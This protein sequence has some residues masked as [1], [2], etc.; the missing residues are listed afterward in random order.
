MRR[1]HI[2]IG[3]EI[4]ISFNYDKSFLGS[5]IINIANN[6]FIGILFSSDKG[7]TLKYILEE[8]FMNQNNAFIIDNSMNNFQQMNLM[9]NPLEYQMEQYQI[10]QQQIYYQK[11]MNEIKFK[12]QIKIKFKVNSDFRKTN[13]EIKFF[14]KLD[15]IDKND[16]EIYINDIKFEY[17][18]CFIPKKEGIYNIILIFKII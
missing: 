13:N 2:I 14:N 18:N 17:Q 16:I 9:I 10:A 7:I 5:P 6:K 12:N 3:N 1:K 8:Y 4:N 11:Y 15:N